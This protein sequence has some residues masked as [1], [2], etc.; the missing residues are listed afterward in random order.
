MILDVKV[1]STLVKFGILH[2]TYSRLGITTIE[3]WFNEVDTKH[4][5]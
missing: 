2:K 4:L 1:L 3:C 5:Q